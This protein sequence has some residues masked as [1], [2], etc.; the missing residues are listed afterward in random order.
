M[1]CILWGYPLHTDTYSYVH[2]GFK[3]ALERAGH[4][5]HWFDDNEYP[6][7][8]DFNYED[9]VF[10]TEGYADKN[11]P[12]L[13]SC[14][15][16]VHVCVNPEK[17]LG[18]CKKLIDM[19]YHQDS[20]DKDNYEFHHDLNDFDELDT[21]VCI[22][23]I[24]SR[25]KGYDITYLAWATDLMPEEFDEEWVNIPRE[26]VFYFIGSISHEGRFKNAHLIQEFG[27][28]CAKIGVK[29]GWSNPWTNPLD[30]PVMRDLMQK[31]FMNPDLRN[32]T[33]KR[34]GTKTCRV[35]K[36]MSYGHLGLT[37]SPKLAAF[38]GPEVI[39][40]ENIQELFEAGLKYR[41]DK[42]LILR[43][44]RYTKEHHTYVN[45]INGLLKLL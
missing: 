35:F 20:M 43:Q 41:D 14:V 21:G 18:K 15:Y 4:D 10:F 16:Y 30:G 31:S 44:M 6:S 40:H 17:Y 2:E 42:E 3:K 28:L 19:R 11:I 32:D 7:H 33:H 9:C 23:R 38:A 36:S 26:D 12:V 29:T 13:A 45:R 1:K 27:S 25:E 34:W 24:S 22:D 8:A 37:N 5:V 39:C